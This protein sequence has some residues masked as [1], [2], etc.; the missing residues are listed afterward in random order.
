MA[1][2]S[3]LVRD[4][5]N[6]LKTWISE[7]CS[8]RR[9]SQQE[10]VLDLLEGAHRGS[11]QPS[12]FDNI[13]P[14]AQRTG[15]GIPFSFIDLFSGI[16]GLRLG[17]E[18]AGGRCVFSSEWDTYC[19]KTYYAW[20]GEVPHGDITKI[21]PAEIPDHDLLV[22]GFPCQPFSIAGVSKKNAL[23]RPHGFKD[24]AQG[25]LFFNVSTILEN[26]RPPA[27]LLENVKNLQS[28]DGG[29][30][31]QVIRSVLEDLGYRIFTK[32]IDAAAWVPQ[33]R[34]RVFIVG[35]D[36]RVFGENPPFV[37]PSEPDSPRPRFRDI[38][39]ESPDSKYTLS[40]HLW[41]YLKDYAQRHKEKGNGFGFG[42]ADFDGVSRTLS[43]RYYKDGSEVLI[44]Q[45]RRN[46]RR[47]T[48][49]EAARLMGF[50]DR[51]PIVVS[52]TQAY[53]QFG[54]AVVPPVA[55]A[56]AR[57]LADVLG[58][59]LLAMRGGC[60]LK[61]PVVTSRAGEKGKVKGRSNRALAGV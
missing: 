8:E 7:R 39:E 41:T 30:T 24:A 51:L 25:N 61:T 16:G 14:P 10:F 37:F 46:P 19:Q 58:W 44:P 21:R 4:I 27:F 26:K 1:A 59:Q 40:T 5:P 3:I 47:L 29:R 18:A 49:R 52:D 11:S 45:K 17:V 23:G 57:Q 60:L 22:A 42:M 38:L 55:E 33:H 28:H 34:E 56:V 32:V 36:V 12:L 43:A 48:P 31:W 50:P 2:N 15:G 54:N 9:V 6:D 20:F 13:Q 53:K 35:F